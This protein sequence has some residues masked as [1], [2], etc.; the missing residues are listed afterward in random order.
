ML[1]TKQYV[2]PA[3]ES[4]RIIKKTGNVPVYIKLFYGMTSRLRKGEAFE[5]HFVDWSSNSKYNV[6]Y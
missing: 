4:V 6:S 2:I 1:A 3:T 5:P